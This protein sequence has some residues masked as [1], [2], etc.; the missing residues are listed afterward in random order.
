MYS[1]PGL[2]SVSHVVYKTKLLTQDLVGLSDTVKYNA[3]GVLK[4]TG[5]PRAKRVNVGLLEQS[6]ALENLSVLITSIVVQH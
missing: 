2:V 5:K 6:D 3:I 4:P 1:D